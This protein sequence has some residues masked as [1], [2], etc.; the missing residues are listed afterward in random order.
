[1][2]QRGRREIRSPTCSS[3]YSHPIPFS[4]HLPS[5]HP[6]FGRT[7]TDAL[8]PWTG[9]HF[10][11]IIKLITFFARAECNAKTTAIKAETERV[12][13]ETGAAATRTDTN[14][15]VKIII[16]ATQKHTAR[17]Q[18]A[19]SLS[20]ALSLPLPLSFSCLAVSFLPLCVCVCEGERDRERGCCSEGNNKLRWRLQHN[21]NKNQHDLWHTL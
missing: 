5:A 2:R 19:R 6:T 11:E 15:H 1:M 14:E 3:P 20:L 9:P 7:S 16:S 18:L 8:R 17:H 13:S 4:R 12:E 21:N 10:M